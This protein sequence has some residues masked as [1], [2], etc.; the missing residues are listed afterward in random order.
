MNID[1]LLICPE[2]DPHSPWYMERP[3]M[4]PLGL[5]YLAGILRKHGYQVKIIDNTIEK[6][7][8]LQLS[9]IVERTSPFLIGISCLSVNYSPA[10]RTAEFLRQHYHI[11]IIVGG[12]HATILPETLQHP[13]I[14][15]ICKGEGEFTLLE[16]CD[17][18]KNKKNPATIPGL[19]LNTSGKWSVTE[20][21]VLIHDLDSLPHPAIDLLPVSKYQNKADELGVYPVLSM[22]TSRGCPFDCTFCS[23]SSIWHRKYRTF[24]AD[25][26]LDELAILIQTYHAKGIYFYEDNFTLSPT[27][28]AAICRGMLQ[29]GYT[30]KWVCEGRIGSLSL[31]LL[32]TM[33]R[34]GCE[35]IKFGIESGSP[36]ILDMIQKGITLEE[37]R[38]TRKLCKK[39]DIKFAC[40]IML[41]IP[42]ETDEDRRKTLELIQDIKPDYLVLNVYI[43]TPKSALYDEILQEQCYAYRDENYFLYL[44]E[45]DQDELKKSQEAILTAWKNQEHTMSLF[46]NLIQKVMVS[47]GALRRNL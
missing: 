2:I 30:V 8:L 9:E 11:P 18:I 41:G 4:P 3:L 5:A 21:R 20:E 23:V 38:H 37:I 42:S 40:F 34:A 17:A 15:F 7:S 33:K 22:S 1:V 32:K 28:V 24:S 45:F 47:V 10:L 44:N 16:L 31:P 12:P 19:M 27:R 46:D 35:T 26:V 6:Y 36:R 14:D 13:Y 25:W 43:P 39:A 29:R